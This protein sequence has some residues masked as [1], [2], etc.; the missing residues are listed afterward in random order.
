MDAITKPI[1]TGAATFTNLLTALKAAGWRGTTRPMG[2]IFDNPSTVETVYLHFTGSS[3]PTGL[4]GNQ[5]IPISSAA[6]PAQRRLEISAG[7][8]GGL[9][10]LNHIFIYATNSVPL[11]VSVWGN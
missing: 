2:I 8:L 5:G 9:P 6:F 1:S 10:E 7:Q 11:T 3:D 4:T